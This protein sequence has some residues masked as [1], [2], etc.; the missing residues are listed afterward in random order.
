MPLQVAG[1]RGVGAATPL[2]GA[3]ILAQIAHADERLVRPH[4]VAPAV[5][6]QREEPARARHL[7]GVGAPDPTQDAL[8]LHVL[9]PLEHRGRDQ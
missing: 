2:L 1:H 6:D 7:P 5:V 4:Q 3:R 8:D 9:P